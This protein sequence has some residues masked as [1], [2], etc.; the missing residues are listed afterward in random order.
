M[1]FLSNSIP[2]CAVY[3]D[4]NGVPLEVRRDKTKG[5]KILGDVDKK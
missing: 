1:Q 5:Y 2:G 4:K 3:L